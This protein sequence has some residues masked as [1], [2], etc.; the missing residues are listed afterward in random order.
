MN[1]QGAGFLDYAKSVFNSAK[2][3]YDHLKKNKYAN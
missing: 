3:I 1:G 2:K